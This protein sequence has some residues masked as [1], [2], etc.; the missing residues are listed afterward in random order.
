MNAIQHWFLEY[1]G[2]IFRVLLL[3]AA[4]P[5]TRLLAA[6]ARR[7]FKRRYTEQTAMLA[8]KAITYAGI[9]M[10]VLMILREFG[11]SLTTLLGAAGVVGVAVGFAAQTSLSNLISGIF[12]IGEKSFQVG[13]VISVG[14][15]TGL[16]HSVD[17]L[18]VKLRTFDNR[19]VRIPNEIL[20]K[21]EVTNVTRFPIRRFDINLGVAY[22]ED[23]G[24]VTA[25]LL[26][27]ADRN[28]FSLDEPE[29]V[30]I[31]KGFGDSA[32]EF[33]LGVWFQKSDFAKLR[34]SI[35]KEIKE[36]FDA[37]GIEIP[38]PHRTLYAG[39]ATN[40]FPVRIVSDPAAATTAND[41]ES[42]NE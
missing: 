30:V 38:F 36:R 37:E 39:A 5:A 16:V 10:I 31:F 29:P 18:S 23:V 1:Y 14:S 28:T 42:K 26:E 32:L 41:T 7:H 13:D 27:I 4:I 40:P 12:M 17:L 19:F 21:T 8:D 3:V 25:V 33:M 2:G 15:T 6:A 11:F 22:K 24:R 34:N 20:V 9:S 35:M